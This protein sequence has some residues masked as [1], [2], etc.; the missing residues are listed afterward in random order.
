MKRI[1]TRIKYPLLIK[2]TVSTCLIV[3]GVIFSVYFLSFLMGPPSLANDQNTVYYSR[4]GDVIGEERGTENRRWVSLEDISEDAVHATLVVEDRHFFDH[5]GFDFKRIL[6][7]LI[8]DIRHWSLKEGASTLSQQYARNLYLTQEKTWSRKLKEAFFTIR[9]EMFYSKEEILEGYLNTIYYGHGAYGI[10]A[11]SNYFFDKPA[12]ELSLAEGAMLASIPRGP[13]Y[14]SPIADRQRAE[15]R[16]QR[17]LHLMNNENMISNQELFLAS[18][19]NLVYEENSENSETTVSGYF[20]EEAS[21]EAAE[22]LKLEVDDIRSGGYEIYT[23]MHESYQKDLEA[24]IK[25]AIHT[26]SEIEAGVLTID[27]QSGEVLAMAGGRDYRESPFNRAVQAKR[28]PG[29]SFKPFLY[30]AALENGYTANTMLLSQPTAFQLDDDEVYQ[31]SNFNGYYANDS[32]TLAQAIALSDNIYAVKTNM[33]LGTENLVETARRFGLTSELPAVPS[34]ALGS[35]AV[36]VKEMVRGYG[37][38]ANGGKEIDTHLIKKIVDRNGK[39]VY[40]REEQEGK[41]MLNP[42]S[43]FILTHLLTGMFDRELDGYMAVTGSTIADHLSRPYAGKSGTTSSDSWMIGYSPSVVTG[44]WIGYDDN[45][46]IEMTREKD[47]AKTIW[48]N[49]MERIHENKEQEAF[50]QPPGLVAVPVDPES[51]QRA[52][53]YCGQSRVMYF[54]KGT[55]P[56]AFCRDH[57]HEENHPDDKSMVERLFDMFGG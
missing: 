33:Y 9:L 53:P 6:S 13:S 56:T 29:S 5:S 46:S 54:E 48:S 49:F 20:Q 27:P 32:I 17:I 7:A 1:F 38:L 2:I 45:R 10:E 37:M 11:A 18:R 23:T 16:Q 28:M 44:V 12:A 30:Y 8:T 25:A 41:S 51:G 50:P 52:T 19:E 42:Q 36:S 39:T 4:G 22:I 3:A 24:E 31:P 21:K 14:Y 34:L 47:Y 15:S 26:E 57:F 35:A 43:A 40:K 55:E